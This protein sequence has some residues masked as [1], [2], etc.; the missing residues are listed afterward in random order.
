MSDIFC[1]K[2]AKSRKTSAVS[3]V[4]LTTC[5]FTLKLFLWHTVAFQLELIEIIE[6]AIYN[7]QPWKAHVFMLTVRERLGVVVG[8]SCY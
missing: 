1:Q 4:F 8:Q 5:L 2:N 6:K 7:K 3:A